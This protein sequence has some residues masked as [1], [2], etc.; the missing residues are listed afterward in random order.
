VAG[1]QDDLKR[2]ESRCFAMKKLLVGSVFIPDERNAAWLRLQRQFLSE[3]VGDFDHVV[4][5]NRADASVFD[6]VPIIGC[7]PPDVGFR[8]GEY[9]RAMDAIVAHFVA[10]SD[11]EN[12]LIIDPDAFPFRGGWIEQL[13]ALMRARPDAG[14]AER[15]FAAPVRCE[16]L[17][18]FPHG[19]AFFAKGPWFRSIDPARF[20][21]DDVPTTNLFGVACK[22]AAL[23]EP[24]SIYDREG[25]QIWLP[26]L[27]TN[28]VNLHPIMGAVY[29]HVFYHHGS[30]SR[31]PQFRAVLEGA[32]ENFADQSVTN[33]RSQEMYAALMR[34]PSRYLSALVAE[35]PV[36]QPR[37]KL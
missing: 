34:N 23:R 30:G 11:Y 27:R 9:G 4:Y 6:R 20:A 12:Y 14:I 35:Q 13:Y 5:L 16:N 3:T 32:Y 22:D 25:K 37:W 33:R 24:S 31:D 8:W 28:T 19:C 26:L 18:T 15:M 7:V 2:R 36:S 29:G 17:D 1:E 21:W 10:S